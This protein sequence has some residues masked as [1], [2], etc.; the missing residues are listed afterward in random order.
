MKNAAIKNNAINSYLSSVFVYSIAVFMFRNL[1]YYKTTINPSAQFTLLGL[2]IVYLL[3]APIFY[4]WLK[5]EVPLSKPY[6][7]LAC[8]KKF[9]VNS[10][11]SKKEAIRRDE[12][13]AFL[14]IMV[15]LFFLPTMISFFFDNLNSIISI[16]KNFNLYS[17]IITSIF[18]LDTLIFS[19]GYAFEGK[20][21]KNIVK[22]V[23]PTLFGW[24]V[25][26]VCYPPFNSYAGRFVP[27]GANDH[28]FFWSAK[29]TIAFRILIVLLLIIY[30]WASFALGTKASNLTNRG[31]VT[32][33]PYSIVRH[34]AYLAKNLTWW[35]A[36][37][38]VMS[39]KFALGMF[40]WSTIYYFRAITEEKH[41]SHDPKYLS[42]CRKVGYK[43]IPYVI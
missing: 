20:I 18:L 11:T 10:I 13:V 28:V 38:P 40:F 37:L 25:A 21:L 1:K 27:W 15:K 35:I 8:L 32:K 7:F 24:A 42:Y 5:R 6:L 19:I 3:L 23:E 43:F 29:L 26:L 22:S 2:L 39:M 14:F 9:I 31:I 4:F 12:K 16:L 36:I 17:L 30:L 41:L 33:F 34:P